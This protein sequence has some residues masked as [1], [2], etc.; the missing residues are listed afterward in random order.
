MMQ[1]LVHVHARHPIISIMSWHCA[2]QWLK[3]TGSVPFVTAVCMPSNYR[4][5]LLHVLSITESAGTTL[6]FLDAWM[7]PFIKEPWSGC[8]GL[9]RRVSLHVGLGSTL[10]TSLYVSVD[11]GG[12]RS[13]WWGRAVC[14]VVCEVGGWPLI[15]WMIIHKY[16]Y[17][18]VHC[19]KWVFIP[20][21][22]SMFKDANTVSL[23]R[24][25][26]K[27]RGIS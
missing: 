1:P 21:C 18:T 14:S 23:N 6:A 7:E 12:L 11:G 19:T 13:Q 26:H 8:R 9:L 10:C 3:L 15:S 16:W 22:R 24:T 20:F 2:I 5:V 27:S 17:N 4:G 25:L